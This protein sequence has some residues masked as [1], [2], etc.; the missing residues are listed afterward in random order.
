M[1]NTGPCEE[2]LNIGMAHFEQL[3]IDIWTGLK[4][5]WTTTETCKGVGAKATSDQEMPITVVVGVYQVSSMIAKVA[6]PINGNN[7]VP[8]LS[9]FC[10]LLAVARISLPQTVDIH[11]A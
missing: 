11:E 7:F 4:G 1:K 3:E 9:M 6:P 5:E 2:G 8:V 10:I